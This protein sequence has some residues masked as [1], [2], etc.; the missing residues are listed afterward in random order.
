[1]LNQALHRI[2]ELLE[3]TLHLQLTGRPPRTVASTQGFPQSPGAQEAQTA[4][5]QA[6][7]DLE[8]LD[9]M[10]LGV[11]RSHDPVTLT[12]AL[13]EDRCVREHHALYI[14]QVSVTR[15]FNQRVHCR[16][17]GGL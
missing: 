14:I 7:L 6:V 8:D 3:R 12:L 2:V 9:L 1:M 5:M 15:D 11:Q 4:H 16:L 13:L 10:T 17:V